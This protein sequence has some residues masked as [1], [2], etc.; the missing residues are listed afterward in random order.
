VDL[1][2]DERFTSLDLQGLPGL[3]H[4]RNAFHVGIQG[5]E[6]RRL[7][8]DK[9][10]G[11]LPEQ[12]YAPPDGHDEEHGRGDGKDRDDRDELVS[13]GMRMFLRHVGWVHVLSIYL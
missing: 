2:D 5:H 4:L 8:E 1:S 12:A 3:H 11:G 10:Y 13:P 7:S 6:A 9:G